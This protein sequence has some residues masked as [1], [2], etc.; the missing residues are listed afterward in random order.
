ME[1]ATEKLGVIY[2]KYNFFWKI[3]RKDEIRKEV[4]I[5]LRCEKIITKFTRI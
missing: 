4:T 2:L 5:Q 1:H 3:R